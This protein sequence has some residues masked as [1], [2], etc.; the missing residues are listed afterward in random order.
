MCVAFSPDERL[1]VEFERD[2]YQLES[3]AVKNTVKKPLL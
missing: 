1:R 3:K 2:G